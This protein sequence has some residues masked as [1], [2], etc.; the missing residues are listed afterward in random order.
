VSPEEIRPFSKAAARQSTR[1]ARKKRQTAILTDS[2]V[3]EALQKKKKTFKKRNIHVTKRLRRGFLKIKSKFEK[4][5]FEKKSCTIH[6][7]QKR[8]F[9]L[10]VR[11]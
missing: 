10:R 2:P 11:K 4:F 1:K 5:C 6:V 7:I 9:I 8:F 3:K